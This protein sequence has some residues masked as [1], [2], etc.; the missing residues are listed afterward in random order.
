MIPDNLLIKLAI[1]KLT[2]IFWKKLILIFWHSSPFF[3]WPCRLSLVL[4]CLRSLAVISHSRLETLKEIGTT[5]VRVIKQVLNRW[6]DSMEEFRTTASPQLRQP[7][8]L[9]YLAGLQNLCEIFK[10]QFFF[11]CHLSIA[12]FWLWV[13]WR[14]FRWSYWAIR[15]SRSSQSG[16]AD[17]H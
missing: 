11:G 16:Y 13:Q 6:L 14:A 4:F 15:W 9:S 3:Y 8:Y 10:T 1:E 5:H 2:L 12:L 7:N 17:I